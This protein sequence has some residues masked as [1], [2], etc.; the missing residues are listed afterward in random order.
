MFSGS[1]CPSIWT[2]VVFWPYDVIQLDFLWS[3]SQGQVNWGQIS[4]SIFLHKLH[5]KLMF[6]TQNFPQNS[7]N[8]ISLLPWCMNFQKLQVKMRSFFFSLYSAI[9][10]PKI[11]LFW[12]SISVRST[13]SFLA[14]TSVF[15]TLKRWILYPF[16][17]KQCFG[18]LMHQ[19]SKLFRS[20][21][22]VLNTT[23]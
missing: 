1:F 3:S 6:L 15:H 9:K 20:E 12:N 19:K 4:N 11:I 16:F 13:L 8:V 17:G 2:V 10:T 14:Y 22:V 21:I 18:N 7:K 5:I 23:V